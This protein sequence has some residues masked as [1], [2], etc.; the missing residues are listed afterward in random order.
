MKK[1]GH[2]ALFRFAA[3]VIGLLLT[4]FFAPTQATAA[5]SSSVPAIIITPIPIEI[6]PISTQVSTWQEFV[7]ACNNY[8]NSGGWIVFS[9]SITMPAGGEATF[10]TA[11]PDKV[12]SIDTN[13]YTF[14]VGSS[15]A[16][17]QNGIVFNGKGT[18]RPVVTVSTDGVVTLSGGEIN[19]AAGNEYSAVSVLNGGTFVLKSGAVTGK[20]CIGVESGANAIL[21]GGSVLASCESNTSSSIGVNIAAGG[22]AII[23]G[24]A[25]LSIESPLARGVICYGELQIGGNCRIH[26]QGS[27]I[28]NAVGIWGGSAKAIV[29]GGELVSSGRAI[30]NEGSLTIT[31]GSM[32]A[33]GENGVGI[34]NQSSGAVTMTAGTAYGS[35][36]GMSSSTSGSR[37][38]I[39]GGELQ[40][41]LMIGASGEVTL[42]GGAAVLIT[43]PNG[44]VLSDQTSSNPTLICYTGFDTGG[45]ILKHSWQN[46]VY[47]RQSFAVTSPHEVVLTSGA[48]QSVSFSVTGQKLNG[49]MITLQDF[50]GNSG[51]LPL[52]GSG[53]LP[54]TVTGNTVKFNPTST[55]M[56]YLHIEDT[57]T[58]AAPTSIQLFVRSPESTSASSSGPETESS[59]ASSS[60]PV[61]SSSAAESSSTASGTASET[62]GGSPPSGSES[63]GPVSYESPT[64]PASKSVSDLPSLQSGV[65][66]PAG[67]KAGANLSAAAAATSEQAQSANSAPTGDSIGVLTLIVGSICTVALAATGILYYRKKQKKG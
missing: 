54:Y 65:S 17:I 61:S 12:I 38:T 10:Q 46:R 3:V 56:G 42:Y 33:I 6:M 64:P 34:T 55:G 57:I 49:A 39:T 36:Y 41:G 26:T 8:K 16:I 30:V 43:N 45:E 63:A 1:T 21:Q 20:S 47:K 5:G 44:V 62:S 11:S 52:S 23:E 18:S 53:S 37:I 9:A 48:L 29:S 28:C 22:K 14:R 2:F 35:Q 66:D 27:S 60:F 15:N 59:P 7:A 51:T 32:R 4:T 13:G 25:F 24:D 67:E 58:C 40:N 50:L 19:Q 31:G